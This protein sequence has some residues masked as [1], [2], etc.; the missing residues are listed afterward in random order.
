MESKK[1][2]NIIKHYENCISKHGDTLKGADW[3]N[4]NDAILRYKIMLGLIKDGET[5]NLLDFGCGAGHMF[6]FMTNQNKLYDYI[7]YSGLDIS[8]KIISLSKEKFPKNNFYCFDILQDD[9]NTLSNFD[10]AIL[11]G[12][13]TEKIDLTFDEMW[14]YF[15]SMITVVFDKVDKGIAFN[16]M[17][18]AVEWERDD[19][20]HL[21]TDLLIDFM[22]KNLSRNFVIRNDYGLYEYTVYL[23]K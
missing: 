3:P 10:Y 14:L 17:S 23:Y 20:F 1:Y 15:K 8:E 2:L 6:E 16:V 5:C 19:L 18:K 12:V 9:I 21:P 22:T 13:F 4:E 7:N 11:N